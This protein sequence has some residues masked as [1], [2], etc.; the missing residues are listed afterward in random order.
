MFPVTD[1]RDVMKIV[2]FRSGVS[3]VA[4]TLA[5]ACRTRCFVAN[6]YYLVG[7]ELRVNHRKEKV[8]GVGF[9]ANFVE[10]GDG[11]RV[12]ERPSGWMSE[13]RGEVRG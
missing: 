5:L 1:N 2:E 12:L 11:M 13:R 9:R 6:Q 8:N 7:R 10:A 3:G 4:R